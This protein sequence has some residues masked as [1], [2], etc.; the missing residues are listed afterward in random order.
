MTVGAIGGAA[1]MNNGQVAPPLPVMAQMAPNPPSQKPN[2]PIK[3]TEIKAYLHA[4]CTKQGIKPE[5]VYES[6]G[7]P[8]RVKNSSVVPSRYPP[9]LW[10]TVLIFTL[11]LQVRLVSKIGTANQIFKSIVRLC[12]RAKCQFRA[13]ILSL[14]TKPNPKRHRFFLPVKYNHKE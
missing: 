3:A 9:V 14:R 5:Y 6:D 7:K 12:T 13:M 4:W 8:P 10:K 2:K 1:V 11:I